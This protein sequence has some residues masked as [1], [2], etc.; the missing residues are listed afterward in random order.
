M[1]K[2]TMVTI[3]Y[4]PAWPF[5]VVAGNWDFSDFET[6][7]DATKFCNDMGYEIVP[8]NSKRGRRILNPTEPGTI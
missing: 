3:I 7:E 6:L 1:K 2:I 5:R 4:N 8:L